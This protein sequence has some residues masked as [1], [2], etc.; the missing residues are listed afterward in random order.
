MTNFIQRVFVATVTAVAIFVSSG[1]THAEV[2]RT[3]LFGRAVTVG[4]TKDFQQQLQIDDKVV[5]KDSIVSIEDVRVIDGVGV[6]IGYTSAGGNACNASYF[7]LAFPKDQPVRIDGPT[8]NC[9]PIT[10]VVDQKGIKFSTDASVTQSGET[11][12][13][14]PSDGMSQKISVAFSEDPSSD[15]W[16]DLR[17]RRI[18]H[19]GE[20]FKYRALSVQ[21]D[22]LLGAD[23]AS[24]L[25][26]VNGVGFVEYKGDVVLATSCLPHQC[27]EA[28]A[29]IAIDLPKKKLFLAWLPS[30]G[31]IVVRPALGA[32]TPAAR[33]ELASW[34][35]Q[36]KR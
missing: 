15:A 18:S 36:W 9:F 28:G 29:I 21:L 26:T 7:V 11:W 22:S 6:A 31:P 32:W 34:S 35:R 23:R 20:F 4:P 12:T 25:P 2:F 33:V 19:P 27:D 17:A 1:L 16:N 13:W 10:Y 3:K 14:T 8:G 24:V 30:R 5:I